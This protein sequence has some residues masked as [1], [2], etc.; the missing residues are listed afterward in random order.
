[1]AFPQR[2]YAVVSH[3]SQP[4]SPKP[5]IVEIRT[6]QLQE[7]ETKNAIDRANAVL[8]RLERRV[9]DYDTQIRLLCEQYLKPLEQ[10]RSCAQQR[11]DRL[12]DQI[13]AKLSEANVERA[14][15]FSREFQMVSCPKA[16]QVDN[17]CLIPNEYIRHKPEADKIAIKRALERDQDLVIPGVHLT[18]KLRL[19]RK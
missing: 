2:L 17:L 1:M 9:A 15:G 18:Q 5:K 19:V 7:L 12:E 10:R 14:D 4:V 11:I 8:D 6:N 16:V 3:T 13:L